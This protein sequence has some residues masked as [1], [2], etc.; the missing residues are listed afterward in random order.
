VIRGAI[1]RI[2][3]EVIRAGEGID[4]VLC[5]SIPVESDFVVACH[6]AELGFLRWFGE[7]I[8]DVEDLLHG[9]CIQAKV[10][11]VLTHQQGNGEPF[12]FTSAKREGAGAIQEYIVARLG[13][14]VVESS[15]CHPVEYLLII[16]HGSSREPR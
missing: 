3:F 4:R 8:P 6:S 10:G 7:A 16:T 5:A 15:R 14:D 13:W 11:Q 12:R 1:D 9:L 2:P